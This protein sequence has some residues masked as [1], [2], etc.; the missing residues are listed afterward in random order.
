[1]SAIK[2]ILTLLK[3]RN[4]VEKVAGLQFLFEHQ[5][6]LVRT[7]VQQGV[8][9]LEKDQ[10]ALV[11][12]W[13]KRILNRQSCV[14]FSQKEL[15]GEKKSRRKNGSPI[16]MA[17]PELFLTLQ[18]STSHVEAL[19]TLKAIFDTADPTSLAPLIAY[20][21][22]S[23]DS[24]QIAFLTKNLGVFFKEKSLL[25]I[26]AGFLAHPD[27]RVVANTLEG[28]ES[29]GT[30][31]SV[32]LFMK[33]L[34]HPNHRIRSNA[35]KA[36]SHS[37]PHESFQ[38]LAEMLALKN[39][40]NQV[41]SACEAIKVV[42]SKEF[43]SL[44]L[45]LIQDP[46]VGQSALEAAACV[47]EGILLR[48][49]ES[50][51]EWQ[52]LRIQ[53]PLYSTILKSLV[54][55]KPPQENPWAPRGKPSDGSIS[56]ESHEQKIFLL[57]P[58]ISTRE[59][60][61]LALKHRQDVFKSISNIFSTPPTEEIE[62]TYSETRMEPFWHVKAKSVVD[63]TSSKVIDIPV[64]NGI[65]EV[66]A[67]EV[68]YSASHG[69]AKIPLLEH[70]IQEMH[71]EYFFDAHSGSKTDSGKFLSFRAREIKAIHELR[72]DNVIIVSAKF[73]ASRIIRE[74]IN[75]MHQ[76][77]PA[78]EI[79]DEHLFLQCIN[80][81]YR[82]IHAFEF[83]WKTRG[84]KGVLE[85]DG[86]TGDLAPGKTFRQMVEE[87]LDEETLFELGTKA[88]GFMIPGSDIAIKIARRLFRK[89]N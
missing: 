78:E 61:K 68:Y 41:I 16:T 65:S 58:R 37:Q 4:P 6:F 69:L 55:R 89:K 64:G 19:D 5:N 76:P 72:S 15:D 87:I 44:L 7:E 47:S 22:T 29:I 85:I 40:P 83:L 67:G 34:V 39:Q 42:A 11:Q 82:P 1:M 43:L 53:T 3:S 18:Q 17:I 79:N 81:Y 32:P 56:V 8:K 36:I 27:E 49:L 63:F 75:E 74:L 73:K 66:K 9:D 28:I 31:A 33:A 77:V 38:T 70:G 54:R 10:E 86:L 2:Q 57:V 52:D 21:E 46:I 80:L 24:R 59:A 26:L 51:P 71:R 50:V 84:E 13:V 60:R 88:A 25:P 30:A 14:V 48:A 23:T 35:A 45:P 20:L 62:L 12:F